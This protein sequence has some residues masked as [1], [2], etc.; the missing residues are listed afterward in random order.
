MLTNGLDILRLLAAAD[1]PLTAT[2]IGARVGL[3]PS[4]VSRTLRV[5]IQAGYVRKPSYHSFA[6]DLGVLALAGQTVK[7]LPVISRTAEPMRLLAAQHSGVVTLAARFHEQVLYLHRTECGR[8]PVVAE[9]GGWPLH[10]SV[11]GL[12]LLADLSDAEALAELKR[13]ARCYGWDRPTPAVPASP[14]ACLVAVRAAY[15]HGALF[16]DGWDR[17]G[18]GKMAIGIAVPGQPPLALSLFGNDPRALRAALELGANAI[19][20]ALEHP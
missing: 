15:R 16:L 8:D 19:I 11:V 1:C 7:N 17:R 12:R 20:H 18:V 9:A 2:A 6:V 5:L 14:A 4:N 10:R 13:S 3:H